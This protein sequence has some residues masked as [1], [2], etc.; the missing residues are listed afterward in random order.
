[1]TIEEMITQYN[2]E[3]SSDDV[4]YRCISKISRVVIEKK[5]D[6]DKMSIVYSFFKVTESGTV[7]VYDNGIDEFFLIQ[8]IVSYFDFLEKTAEERRRK[9]RLKKLGF[10]SEYEYRQDLFKR[11]KEEEKK[12]ES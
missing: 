6:P 9:E 4:Y 12:E 7:K 11:K 5:F 3:K 1:M 8:R 10:N 2:F